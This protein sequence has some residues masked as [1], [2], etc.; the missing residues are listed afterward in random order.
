LAVLQPDETVLTPVSTPRVSD[1]PI[2]TLRGRVSGKLDSVIDGGSALGSGEDTSGVVLPW[3]GIAADGEGHALEGLVDGGLVASN[4][5]DGGD[6]QVGVRSALG[7]STGA[8]LSGVRVARFGI[9]T[10]LVNDPLESL[11]RITTVATI[12]AGVAVDDFLRG[13][14]RDGVTSHQVG[15]LNGLGGRESPAASALFLV[16]DR[17]G[18]SLGN[19]IDGTRR[20]IGVDGGRDG[21]QGLGRLESKEL[22]EFSGR[23]ISELRVTKSGGLGVLVLFSNLVSGSNEVTETFL[24]LER[25]SVSLVPE[26]VELIES[27]RDREGSLGLVVLGLCQAGKR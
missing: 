14:S 26:G 19:P 27:L 10:A 22:L 5:G 9:E 23:P 15:G 7:R 18:L 8:V 21:V 1:D 16:L 4:G 12:I 11:L 2:P 25:S 17:G 24:T 20:G 6:L 13:T 3:L